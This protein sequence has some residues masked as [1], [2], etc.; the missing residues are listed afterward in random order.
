MKNRTLYFG[1]N[2]DILREKIP[3]ESFDLIYLD[4]PFNSNRSYN[5][6]FK[7]EAQESEAQIKAFE[8]SWHWT[9]ESKEVF[10]YLVRKTNQDISDLMLA[11]EKIIG[12]NDVLAYLTMMTVRLIE[13]HRVLKKTGS[14]YLHCDPT[15][16]H[17]LKIVLDVIFGKKNFMNEII[18]HYRRWTTAS[19]RFQR[20]HD[21]IF[22][23]T[24][25]DNYIFT[26]PLQEYSNPEWVED[27][28]RGVVNGKLV[29]LK[30]E[31]GNY[32]KRQKESEGVLMH[33]VWEDINFIAPTSKERLGYPTQKPEALL[34]RIIKASSNKG[35]W[36]LDPFCGCGTTV[37]V[38]ERLKRNWVGIDITSLAI[39]LIKYRIKNQFSLG[40]KQIYV[41]GLPTDLAGAKELFKKDPFQFE[42]W[43]LDLINAVPAQSKTKENMRGA[44]KGIDGIVVF[45]K[46]IKN[47]N[48]NGNG[49]GRWEY[50]KAIVQIKGGKVQRRDIAVLKGDVA[51]E[52]AEAGIFITLEKPTKPMIQESIDA[53]SFK[54][55]ITNSVEFPKIQILTVE[56]LLQ[57]K[58]L[59]LPQGLVKNYYKEAKPIEKNDKKNWQT[60][61]GVLF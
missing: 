55:P 49:N 13:L 18:W 23:Y 10:D 21:V 15:A 36:I 37:S 29:R 28:V 40:N 19:N 30:D 32:I 6:L 31:K 58:K 41:D 14:L 16:S 50:G 51:R 60:N 42:Y 34:E 1:D 48:G 2:L 26:K 52:K 35:D 4:P 38:S 27:T 5:V 7:E 9:R 61:I 25:T 8:D 24:K 33:D 43:A 22:Y 12:H 11:L 44:D 20:M 57:N 45:H 47:G 54:I 53:G 59:N 17:Y 56:D 39:N 3:N 46:D